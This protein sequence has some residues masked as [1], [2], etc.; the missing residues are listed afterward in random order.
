MTR[1]SHLRRLALLGGLAAAGASALVAAPGSATIVCPS[2][3][4][5]PSPYCSNVPPTATTNAA[6]NVRSTQAT[7]NG[8]VG[9]NV[10]GGDPTTYFF[11][12]GKTPSYGHQTIPGTIGS[13]P[14]GINPPS[15]YCTTPK[16]QAVS[17]A[18]RQLTPCTTYHFQVFARNPDGSAGGGDQT[19]T[20]KFA[21]PLKHVS[22][23]GSVK[24]GHQFKVKFTLRYA[25]HSVTI[26]IEGHGEVLKSKTI[27]PVSAGKHTVTI[28]AP[29][30][31]GNYNLVVQANL[32]C[33]SQSLRKRLKVH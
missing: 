22:A 30:A 4:N 24:A 5:P 20:T 8:V 3:V 18:I 23:P 19:F 17:A 26:R 32:K 10:S 2:G 14:P 31:T 1:Y 29:R 25:A 11:R 6:T 12:F 9:P 16:T 13:C 27:A 33:G 21:P 7:L 15:P 28:T